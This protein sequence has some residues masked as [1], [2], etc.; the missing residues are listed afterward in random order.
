MREAA[1]PYRVRIGID[2]RLRL[3]HGSFVF[4]GLFELAARG[5]I[6]LEFKWQRFDA[7]FAIPS[8]IERESD[9]ARRRVCFDIHD[10]SYFLCEAAL[11]ESDVY[12]KRSLFAPD[13]AHLD[14]ARRSRILPFGPIFVTSVP[15]HR[16]GLIAGWIRRGERGS[17]RG[18]L[19]YFRL[20]PPTNFHR[21]ANFTPSP[22]IL[23][24]TR[25]W[26]DAEVTGKPS[27]EEI[28]AGRIEIVRAL[29]DHFGPRFIGGLVPTPLACATQPSLLCA[30]PTHRRAYLAAMHRCLIGV[31]TPGLHHSI[32]WKLGE[33]LASALCVVAPPFRNTFAEPFIEGR[34]YVAFDTPDRCIAQCERLLT[35]PALAAAMRAAN[36]AYHRE[37]GAP[38]SQILG[39]LDRAFATSP[40]NALPA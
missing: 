30:G 17:W 31:Y 12:F 22:H 37:H 33:Y 3:M 27:A 24:Q 38:A 28:N 13:L 25:L 40:S 29:R 2:P 32:A 34:H 23:L 10:R 7:P 11:A 35:D 16:M 19:D 15:H 18:L 8:E 9:G 1:P 6:A 14:T 26:T 20:P 5:K 4:A 21:E 36:A 39:C